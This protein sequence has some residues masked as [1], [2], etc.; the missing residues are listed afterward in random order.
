MKNVGLIVKNAAQLVTCQSN[1]MPK[2]GRAMMDPGIIEDG[3]VA[4]SNG[5]IAGVGKTAEIVGE[6]RSETVIN[7]KNQV[8]CPGFVDSHTHIVFGGDRLDEFELRVKGA[9]Y[10]E[11]MEAGGGIVSTVSRTREASVDQLVS[12]AARRLD[13]MLELGTTT[14]EIKTGY[15]LDLKTELKML[16]AIAELDK[17]HEI[18]IIPTFLAA[19]AIPSEWKGNEDEYTD[20]ICHE[21]I[22]AAWD[23]YQN[24]HFYTRAD[25]DTT[26]DQP[27]PTTG[28]TPAAKSVNK[29]SN[30]QDPARNFFIDVF[31]EQ[32]A[33]NLNQ[34]K[35]VIDTASATGFKVKAHVDEFTNLGC[36]SYAIQRGATSIDHLDETSDEEI[37]LLAGSN[38]IGIVTPAVN[39]N[40]GSKEFAPARK[41]IDRGCAIALSTDYNPGSA[42]CPSLPLTMAIACRY[43]RLLPGEAF[44][45]VTIN[46]AFAV[47][48]GKS[49]GSLEAGKQ[50]DLLILDTDDYRQTA[51]EFGR[52]FVATRIKNGI[53]TGVGS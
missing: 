43:Q 12:S 48:A 32:N 11:I 9:S 28:S 20:L 18:E 36:G 3:A 38:T 30:T 25:G 5:K 21:M 53:V 49:S 41:M 44:N 31:C 39:F 50:A 8:V 51:Y 40:L 4:V 24:S 10:L 7:A 22:P 52:N 33:F 29:T 45:A 42:P 37:E 16:E 13:T 27:G 23:W 47:G 1:G 15:G 26:E 17:T 14:V 19:H 6:F 35:Q 2:K 34:A 46:A